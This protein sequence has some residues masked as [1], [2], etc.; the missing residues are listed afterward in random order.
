VSRIPWA[1]PYIGDEEIEAVSGLLRERR[2]SMGPQVKALEAELAGLAGRRHGVAVA[3]GTVALEVAL[4]V[5]G[6]GPGD[7]VL[8]S[9]LSY[10]ATVSSIV[11]RGAV[12]VF[13]DVDA[14]TLNIDPA[15]V[16]DA[17]PG[18]QALLAADYCG[19]PVDYGSLEPICEREGLTL[20]VD[21]AQSLGTTYDG[22]P[23]LARGVVST[24]S[25]HTAKSFITGEGGMVFLDDGGLETLARRV[26][27]QGEIPGRKY[28]HDTLASNFRMTDYAAAIGRVQIG[29]FEA[30]NA[31]RRELTARYDAAF[32]GD[33][34]IEVVAHHPRGCPSRFSYA[35]L[36]DER[37]RVAAELA[38]ADI[39]TRSL[40]PITAY[41]QPIPEYAPFAGAVCPAAER[42]AERVLNL[43][44]F[45]E[46]TDEQADRVCAALAAATRG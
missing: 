37:D 7:R 26:R 14:S 24:T 33:A 6:I 8:V 41:R 36:V 3:N 39:E 4:R 16:A 44:L 21:G 10:I 25:L 17:A 29:R 34:G 2:I 13:C 40:Y 22:S 32:A 18:A 9:A 27:G 12:P 15:A 23:T 45:Y 38:A 35:V 28:I 46:M 30:V 11:L 5:A 20:L 19:S 1:Q 31:R 43:P 42:A